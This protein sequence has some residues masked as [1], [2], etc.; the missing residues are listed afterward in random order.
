MSTQCCVELL[1]QV[2]TY[3][4]TESDCNNSEVNYCSKLINANPVQAVILDV[5]N[6]LYLELDCTEY[7]SASICRRI[8]QSDSF[9]FA[10]TDTPPALLYDNTSNLIVTRTELLRE[11]AMQIQQELNRQCAPYATHPDRITN[12]YPRMSCSDDMNRMSGALSAVSDVVARCNTML[13][14][15]IRSEDLLYNYWFTLLEQ[16]ASCKIHDKE[17]LC[18][19]NNILTGKFFKAE[20]FRLQIDADV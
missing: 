11:V 5:Y 13:E 1:Q 9:Q 15:H 7:R 4:Q 6:R 19:C 2:I 8:L 10:Y 12:Q 18:M 3:I 17:A 20:M 14:R 16:M